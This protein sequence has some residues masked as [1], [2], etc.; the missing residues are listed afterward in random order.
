MLGATSRLSLRNGHLETSN[1]CK[2]NKKTS[3]HKSLTTRDLVSLDRVT[4]RDAVKNLRARKE[5]EKSYQYNK[6]SLNIEHND[7]R[8]PMQPEKE[9]NELMSFG[10]SNRLPVSYSNIP[11]NLDILLFSIPIKYWI[12]NIGFRNRHV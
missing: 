10:K 8:F 11:S 2:N 3:V 6:H 7:F 5:E 12:S 1:K 9:L 4:S